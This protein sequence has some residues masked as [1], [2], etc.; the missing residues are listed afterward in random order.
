MATSFYFY[1]LET[2]GISAKDARIMQFAGQRTDMQLQPIGEPHNIL[3]KLSDDVLP[4]PDAVLI[5]GITPQKTLAEGVTEAA[6]LK[7]FTE[8]VALPDTIFVGFNTVRFDDEFMRYTLYRNFYDPYEWQWQDGR[9][10]WDLLDVVRMMRALRPDGINWPFAADGKPTNRL[11]LI[12]ALNGLDHQAAHDALSDVQATIAVAKLIRD[13]QPKLFEYLLHMRDKKAVAKTVLAPDPF[14][15]TS[16][17]YNAQTEKT[18]VVA[19]LSEY[20][21]GSALVFDLRYD[22]R[23]F[24]ELTSDA[25]AEALRRR[26]DEPGVRLPVKQLKF[27]RCPAVAPLSVLDKDSQQRLD[28]SPQTY[29]ANLAVLR[30]VQD[31]LTPKVVEAF[32][33]LDKK[34]QAQFEGLEQDADSRLYDGFFDRQDALAMAKVRTTTKDAMADLSVSFQDDRLQALLPLYKARNYPVSLNDEERQVWE[35]FR[36]K[37]LLDG[38]NQSRAARFFARLAELADQPD[39]PAEKRYVLEELQLYGQSI[40]PVTE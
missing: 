39:L 16:G 9:S 31:K 15:Y 33:L 30:E 2:S 35:L 37:R 20:E 26:H 6:F 5:T 27:N 3:V 1:D 24:H 34:R 17:R 29:R 10:R 14:V 4:E 18:T 8:E 25:L 19:T 23:E 32:R 13:K 7:Q 38:G 40:L 12:T 11:E 36:S 21:Q 28:L 22:P